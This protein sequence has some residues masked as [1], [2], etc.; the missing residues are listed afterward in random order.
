VRPA[1]AAATTATDHG[2]APELAGRV[3]RRADE[4]RAGARIRL[5]AVSSA[6]AG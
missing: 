5:R 4:I 6:D 1:T 3:R 2:P